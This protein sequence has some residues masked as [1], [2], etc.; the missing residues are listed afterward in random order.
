MEIYISEN[1]LQ[2]FIKETKLYD[3]SKVNMMK[4]RKSHGI[5]YV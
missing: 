3:K 1:K 4:D 5:T 2:T